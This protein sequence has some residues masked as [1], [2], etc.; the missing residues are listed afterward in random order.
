MNT[1]PAPGTPAEVPPLP[2]PD[3]QQQRQRQEGPVSAIVMG[4][5]L[6][7]QI[8]FVF[9]ASLWPNA[10]GNGNGDAAPQRQ[11]ERAQ[12]EG[13]RAGNNEANNEAA[14]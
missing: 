1:P 11:P 12:P 3:Q 6:V 14:G 2:V 4:L 7:E 9:V 10:I 13:E 5:R 8:L